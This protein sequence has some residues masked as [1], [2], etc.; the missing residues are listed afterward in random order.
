M[1]SE[2][3]KSCSRTQRVADYLEELRLDR[4]TVCLFTNRR[5]LTVNVAPS[6]AAESATSLGTRGS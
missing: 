4:V 1:G 5:R 6:A 2:H 3:T